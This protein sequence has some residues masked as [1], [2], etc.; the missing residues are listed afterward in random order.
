MKE[1]TKK[2]LRALRVDSVQLFLMYWP[3]GFKVKN[4][5]KSSQEQLVIYIIIEYNPMRLDY[6]YEQHKKQK[7]L[8]C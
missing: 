6:R 2:S 8:L 3:F 5:R 4:L 1:N 7:V